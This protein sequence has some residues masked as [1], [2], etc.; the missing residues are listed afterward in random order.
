M[1]LSRP[2]VKEI[3]PEKENTPRDHSPCQQLKAV[4]WAITALIAISIIAANIFISNQTTT[5]NE[6]I[7]LKVEVEKLRDDVVVGRV[8]TAEVRQQL[9][10]I[11]NSLDRIERRL[12]PDTK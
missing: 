11:R 9:S 10:A 12:Y 3:M 5:S 4:C 1:Y 6:Q 2:G 7:R 8:A